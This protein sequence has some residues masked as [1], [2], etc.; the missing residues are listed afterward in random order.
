MMIIYFRVNPVYIC[1]LSSFSLRD[2][3]GGIFSMKLGSFKVVMAAKPEA[4]KDMLL[5]KS[6]DYAGRT[7]T[8]AFYTISLG[9]Y[10]LAG[11]LSLY[12]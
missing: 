1:H 8:H 6:V 2:S 4:V 12:V 7:Q 3:Y 9:K 5:T 10:C 11:F